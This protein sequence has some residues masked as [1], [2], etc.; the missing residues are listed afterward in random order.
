MFSISGTAGGDGPG[1]PARLPAMAMR[2]VNAARDEARYPDDAEEVVETLEEAQTR[3]LA[4]RQVLEQLNPHGTGVT[5]RVGEVD[6]EYR[7]A[8]SARGRDEPFK[9]HRTKWNIGEIG[10]Q[11]G[12]RHPPEPVDQAGIRQNSADAEYQEPADHDRKGPEQS[13]P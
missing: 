4:V 12:E 9:Q 11:S 7:G 8:R 6:R 3:H 5:N 2:E 1:V 13:A 10:A